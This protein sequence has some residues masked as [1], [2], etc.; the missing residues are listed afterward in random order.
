[1]KLSH[2]YESLCDTSKQRCFRLRSSLYFLSIGR[3]LAIVFTIV[4]IV[5]VLVL[6]KAY[7]KLILLWLEKQ[8]SFIVAATICVLFV[9]VSLPISIGYIVLVLASGYLF[10]VT[11]GLL[12]AHNLLKL[13]GH[14]PSIFKLTRN[15]MATAIMQVISGPLCFKIVFCSRLTP[16][17]FGLQNTIFALS[18]V[19]AKIYHVASLIG[20]FPA[21]FVAVYVGSTLRSMQDVLENNHISSTTYFFAAVQLFCGVALIWWI[22]SKARSELLKVLAAAENA[23]TKSS[24]YSLV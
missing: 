16:I 11:R 13:L 12:L 4:V 22:G 17:P 10:G 6:C 14:H 9:I 3:L 21:Q 15:D 20:L 2:D 24:S 19:S 23:S 18:N 7:I 5:F 8:D 1:M